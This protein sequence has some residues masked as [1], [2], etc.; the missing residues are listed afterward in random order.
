MM[1]QTLGLIG[2]LLLKPSRFFRRIAQG[3]EPWRLCLGIYASSILAAGVFYAYKP[4]GF[5]QDSYSADVGSHSLSF[6][7]L[8]GA[9]GG[10]LTLV[11]GA[12]M[13]VLLRFLEGEWRI[14]LAQITLVL[15]ATHV[16]YLLLFVALATA[17]AAHAPQFYKTAELV[18][19]LIGFIVTVI[20]VKTVAKT[21]APKV[22]V[23]AVVSSLALV[24]TLFGLYLANA[25]PSDILKVLLFI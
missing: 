23:S 19:S 8:M 13:R 15:L 10:I 11:V 3:E 9:L 24:A 16:W 12:L 25:L 22:A 18:F 2:E 7:L 6:W 20:G 5:P 1:S 14:S 4:Q 17:T 21:T